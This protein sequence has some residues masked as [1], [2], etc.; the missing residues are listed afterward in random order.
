MATSPSPAVPPIGPP[1]PTPPAPAPAVKPPKRVRAPKGAAAGAGAPAT[2]R[3][4]AS[5]FYVPLLLFGIFVVGC[6][7][8]L[9]LR[10]F[11]DD[12][13][14]AE[15][16]AVLSAQEEALNT[17]AAEVAAKEAKMAAVEEEMKKDFEVIGVKDGKIHIKRRETIG[18]FPVRNFAPC[19]EGEE[20]PLAVPEPTPAVEPV[21]ESPQAQAPAKPKPSQTWPKPATDWPTTTIDG[22]VEKVPPPAKKVRPDSSHTTHA[23]VIEYYELRCDQWG[24]SHLIRVAPPATMRQMSAQVI[25][26]RDIRYRNLNNEFQMR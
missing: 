12:R 18:P 23:P 17:R 9:F 24:R 3:E 2:L 8:F 25:P 16:T 20:V 7:A 14:I 19:E 11:D 4:V 6:A 10:S 5:N 13:K 15:R 22:T 26:A 1:A 21:V